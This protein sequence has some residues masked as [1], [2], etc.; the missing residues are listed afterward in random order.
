[1]QACKFLDENWDPK[2]M[3]IVAQKNHHTKFFQVNSEFNVPPGFSNFWNRYDLK[4]ELNRIKSESFNFFC[5]LGTIIDNE[6]CHPKNNDF[7]LCAQNGPIV[8][9]IKVFIHLFVTN[10]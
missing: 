9:I 7:Y 3:V 6:V 8:S 5:V 4:E 10:I 1:M 2:F